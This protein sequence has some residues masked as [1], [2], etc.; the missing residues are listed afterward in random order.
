MAELPGQVKIL[1]VDDDA[2]VCRSLQAILEAEGYTVV[3]AHEGPEGLRLLREECPDLVLLDALM[4]N[5][6]GWEVCRRMR[7]FSG[8]PIL[9]LT[10]RQGEEDRRRALQAGASGYLVKPVAL[11][12][13][14][15]R[16]RAALSPAGPPTGE[17]NALRTGRD[18][19]P[20]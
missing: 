16:I 11:N 20:G 1:V 2:Y 7:A 19:L 18:E 12:E 15:A 13:L 4:P 14:R 3:T 8:V 10:A 6:D 17:G 9:M 5:M